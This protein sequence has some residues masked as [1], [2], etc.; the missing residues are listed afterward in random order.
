MCSN[1]WAR[2]SLLVLGCG[3]DRGSGE[4]LSGTSIMV[5]S[6][7]LSTLTGIFS[8]KSSFLQMEPKPPFP[9]GCLGCLSKEKGGLEGLAV[10]LPTKRAT[11]SKHGTDNI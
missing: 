5:F 3:E 2:E 4:A 6:S 8:L 10:T 9:P 1:N 7:H 11:E